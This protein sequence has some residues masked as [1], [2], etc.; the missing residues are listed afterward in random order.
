MT[1]RP[2]LL[3]K[4]TLISFSPLS[5]GAPSLSSQEV[6]IFASLLFHQTRMKLADTLQV[7]RADKQGQHHPQLAQRGGGDAEAPSRPG[8]THHPPPSTSP[9]SGNTGAG[10]TATPATTTTRRQGGGCPA[11]LAPSRPRAALTPYHTAAITPLTQPGPRA[12]PQGTRRPSPLPQGFPQ[13]PAGG[14]AAV[15]ADGPAPAQFRP[16]RSPRRSPS[17]LTSPRSC[18]MAPRTPLARLARGER[19]PPSAAPPIGGSR[20]KKANQRRACSRRA[21]RGARREL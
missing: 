19:L 8:Q 17:P 4:S 10:R 6:N 14:S 2:E 1:E 15:G 16:R 18:S 5:G 3:K 13:R 7:P 12:L 20:E 21:A 11:V 9:V